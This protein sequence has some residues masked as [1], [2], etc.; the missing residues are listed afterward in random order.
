MRANEEVDVLIVGARCAGASTAML[1]ARAG[2]DVLVVDR[3]EQG[4]DTLS[5]HALMRPGILMLSRWDVLDAVRA[6]GTPPVTE[7]VYHYGD[8]V[9]AIPIRPRGDVDALYAPRRTV[10]DPILVDA[11]RGAGARVRFGVSFRDVVRDASGRV[12]GARLRA[13]GEDQTIRCRWLIG[14]DGARS[15]V[16][17]AAGAVA[18]HR[19]AGSSATAYAFVGGLP[20]SAYH[21]H[22]RDGASAGLIPTNDGMA[23]VW[24]G[25]DMAG[26]READ[27]HDV[28]SFFARTLRQSAPQLAEQ[29]LDGRPLHGQRLF[30]G[31]P[32]VTR[33]AVGPGWLLVGDA[34]SMEDPIGAHG[35]T[36]ALIGAE[37]AARAVIDAAVATDERAVF[38]RYATSRMLL[39]RQMLGPISHMTRLGHD[40]AGLRGVHL[41]ANAG[42][43]AEWDTVQAWPP[44]PH[45]AMAA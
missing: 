27:R 39:A 13:D 24:A 33:R 8:D 15:K 20:D 2:L 37:L 14:A 12:I 3:A 32:G 40:I 9:A 28:P 38:S 45:H 34:A 1:L 21:N 41:A 36:K 22:F 42:L 30:A 19:A 5:T 7:V 17:G 35:M 18:V 6:A 25:I 31:M 43:K 29:V 26:L 4:A 11:A 23:N 16:A 10:L 44:L